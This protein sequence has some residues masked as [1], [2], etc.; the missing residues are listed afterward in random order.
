MAKNKRKD[1]IIDTVTE[2]LRDYQLDRELEASQEAIYHENHDNEKLEISSTHAAVN[3][4]VNGVGTTH[5]STD[6][7]SFQ[8]LS[9]D[10][11][12]MKSLWLS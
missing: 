7:N 12:D 5:V 4:H 10:V 3:N 9:N 2:G 1:P 6:S 11:K 8:Q